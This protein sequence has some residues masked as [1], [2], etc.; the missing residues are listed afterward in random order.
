MSH[1]GKE[2]EDR[3]VDLEVRLTHQEV[4]L[5][6]LT[7]ASVRQ[8]RVIEELLVQLKQIKGMLRQMDEP[9]PVPGDE[10]PPPH[11]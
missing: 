10:P 5:D 3:V 9:A 11:Y 1:L 7:A 2:F 8:G 6:N 4:G